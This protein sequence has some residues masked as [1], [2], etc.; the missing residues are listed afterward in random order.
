MSRA[1]K[2]S[3]EQVEAAAVDRRNGLSWHKLSRKYKCAINTLRNA[4]AEY[5]DEFNPIHIVQRSELERQLT[6]TQSELSQAQADIEK[7]KTILREEL[8]LPF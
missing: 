7:I 3:L 4:L 6:A 1:R 8:K 5:S 2:L